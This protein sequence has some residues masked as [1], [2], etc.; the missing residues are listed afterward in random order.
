MPRPIPPSVRAGAGSLMVA[1]GAAGRHAPRAASR[2]SPKP[3]AELSVPLAGQLVK[4]TISQ[5]AQ[6]RW[7]TQA[8]GV[9][10]DRRAVGVGA[11]AG[12]LRPSMEVHRQ[13][14]VLALSTALFGDPCSA[15]DMGGHGAPRISDT[16]CTIQERL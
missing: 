16:I 11:A 15:S 1:G 14:C 2:Y 8:C 13:V 3:F 6:G 10:A 5:G 7:M 12:P 9:P 4:S